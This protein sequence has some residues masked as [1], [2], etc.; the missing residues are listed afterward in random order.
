MY[1][2]AAAASGKGP[3]SLDG[4]MNSKSSRIRYDLAGI[5]E[6][7]FAGDF[8]FKRAGVKRERMQ[9][10]ELAPRDVSPFR[11]PAAKCGFRQNA[12]SKN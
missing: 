9:S 6:N 7:N 8:L 10:A 1:L 3:A 4:A 11:G 2:D 5:F 12:L